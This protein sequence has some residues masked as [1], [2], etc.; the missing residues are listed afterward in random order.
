MKNV[1]IKVQSESDHKSESGFQVRLTCTSSASTPASTLLWRVD[2]VGGFC[3]VGNKWKVL[4]K[5]S[6]HVVLRCA[7]LVMFWVG[8][9]TKKELN[10]WFRICWNFELML[11]WDSM[12]AHRV[13]GGRCLL[14]IM[15]INTFINSKF[16]SWLRELA[17]R[18]WTLRHL[19]KTF[20]AASHSHPPLYL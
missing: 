14:L 6:H 9:Q 4:V 8:W 19:W 11:L 2:Q 16:T 18:R 12:M 13:H 10:F 5:S 17:L 1:K 20:L 7:W 3:I 15:I